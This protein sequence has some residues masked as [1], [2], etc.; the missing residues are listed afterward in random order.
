VLHAVQWRHV[1]IGFWG[2]L[3]DVSA[4]PYELFDV[5]ALH[6]LIGCQC[7]Y[8][9]R[10]LLADVLEHATALSLWHRE[11]AVATAGAV[12]P[13]LV[14][15]ESEVD[16]LFSYL[17]PGARERACGDAEM[18]F[19]PAEA[20]EEL[21]SDSDAAAWRGFHVQTDEHGAG[22]EVCAAAELFVLANW[23]QSEPVI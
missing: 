17:P 4:S 10:L 22:S 21:R 18:R 8:W 7:A 11:A 2:H 6:G 12:Q 1:R 3:C 15:S 23:N 16:F 9:R 20:G 19:G 5:R 13:E 14:D